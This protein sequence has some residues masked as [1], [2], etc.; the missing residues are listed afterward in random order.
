MIRGSFATSN[1]LKYLIT[2]PKFRVQLM[3]SK[4]QLM[5]SPTKIASILDTLIYSSTRTSNRRNSS[6]WR[7]R[8]S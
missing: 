3:R 1:S 2:L 7:S 8:P 6:T 4:L 5:G